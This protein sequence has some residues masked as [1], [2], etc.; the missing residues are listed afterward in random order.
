MVLQKESSPIFV[1]VSVDVANLGSSHKSKTSCVINSK[2]MLLRVTMI[3][4]EKPDD[5]DP[6]YSPVYLWPRG[7]HPTRKGTRAFV[8]NHNSRPT[9]NCQLTHQWSGHIRSGRTIYAVTN[10]PARP[11]V[12]T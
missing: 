2:V 9:S 10:G 12:F 1:G 7:L 5:C 6:G 8:D 3:R 4:H 11:L